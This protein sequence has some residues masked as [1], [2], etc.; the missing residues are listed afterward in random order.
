MNVPKE[1]ISC[2]FIIRI[3]L[4]EKTSRSGRMRWR[5]HITQ[6]PTKKRH[7]FEDLEDMKQFVKS[8]IEEMESNIASDD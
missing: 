5:G 7:H 2:S 4:E 1:E 3:W 6:I 8:H